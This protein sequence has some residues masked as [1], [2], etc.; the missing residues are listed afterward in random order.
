MPW[1]VGVFLSLLSKAKS[2]KADTVFHNFRNVF[3][4]INL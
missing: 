2:N 3:S 4:D 1:K